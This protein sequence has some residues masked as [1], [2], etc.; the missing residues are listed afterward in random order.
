RRAGRE[1]APRTRNVTYEKGRPERGKGRTPERGARQQRSSGGRA[2]E[3]GFR[4]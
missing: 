1:M 2:G 3:R 4:R